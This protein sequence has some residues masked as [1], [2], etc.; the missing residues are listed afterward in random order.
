[1]VEQ[2]LPLDI[3]INNVGMGDIGRRIDEYKMGRLNYSIVSYI[4]Q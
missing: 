1:M 4:L 2:A 3:N